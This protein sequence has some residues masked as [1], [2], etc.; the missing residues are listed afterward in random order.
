[1]YYQ[2]LTYSSWLPAIKPGNQ[3]PVVRLRNGAGDHPGAEPAEAK[4]TPRAQKLFREPEGI[5]RPIRCRNRHLEFGA[6]FEPRR[7]RND[8]GPDPAFYWP[9]DQSGPR[10]SDG[11]VLL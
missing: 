10:W 9:G 3:G 5:A 11:E 1:M 6:G 2:L 8:P 4:L 7:R